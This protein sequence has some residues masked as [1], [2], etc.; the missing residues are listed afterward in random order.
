LSIPQRTNKFQDSERLRGVLPQK[1]LRLSELYTNDLTRTLL[2][3]KFKDHLRQC[4][5]EK[6][7]KGNK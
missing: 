4:E 6:V 7:I 1:F 2:L 5:M 3:L